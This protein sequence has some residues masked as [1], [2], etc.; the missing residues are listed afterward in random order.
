[1][2]RSLR[3]IAAV[4]A[5]L[6]ALAACNAAASPSPSPSASPSPSGGA[7]ASGSPSAAPSVS[8]SPEPVVDY[9]GA[10]DLEARL[11][12]EIGGVALAKVSLTGPDFMKL[13]TP[14]G[15]GQ[16]TSLLTEL[17]RTP[18][19]LAVAEAYDPSQI[20]TFKEGLFRVAGADTVQLLGLWV[21]SQQAAESNRLQVSNTTV[22]GRDLTR[23]T[24]PS[25]DV[26]GTTYAFAEGDTLWLIATD[27]QALLEEALA[28]VE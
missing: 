7:A 19:D 21:A 26:G 8:E 11:P 6:T 23:I 15:Q 14:T 24:D 18:D 12:D 22:S 4:A 20:L 13:G 17:G 16:M 9:H 3:T 1:M 27:D 10:P 25:I 2:D 5:L 28:K